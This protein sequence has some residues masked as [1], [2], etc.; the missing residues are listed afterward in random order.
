MLHLYHLKNSRSFR[1]V[2]L[3]EELKLHYPIDY[4]L[5]T[6]DRDSKT[7]LAPESLTEIHP[8]GKAP[9]LLD[10]T[11]AV[12]EQSM[13]ESA[14]IIEYLL[15]NY[16]TKMQFRPSEAKL[17]RDY[18]Y[19]LHFAEGTL[20]PPLVMGLILRKSV[21]KSPWFVKPVAKKFTTAI[22]HA[23]LAK[24]ITKALAMI[25]TT[26]DKQPWLAERFSAADIQM[27]LAVYGAKLANKITS[28]HPNI[29]AWLVRCE[30]RAAFVRAKEL[31]GEPL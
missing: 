21:K 4:Q 17:W 7:L 10:D 25:E 2:W 9:I 27:Y 5:H 6:I 8:M 18:V 22:N 1:I 20:M 29:Q 13:A 12:G 26:L 15:T 3:L 19:W 31:A 28:N 23:V 16:D 11:L 24:N 30:Q 14:A